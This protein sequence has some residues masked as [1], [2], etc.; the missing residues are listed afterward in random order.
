MQTRA[1][2]PKCVGLADV[3]STNFHFGIISYSES[4]TSTPVGQFSNWANCRFS[5]PKR[6]VLKVNAAHELSD[7]RSVG[8]ISINKRYIKS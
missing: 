5:T 4:P 1:T 7:A 2:F 8:S 3:W 6:A